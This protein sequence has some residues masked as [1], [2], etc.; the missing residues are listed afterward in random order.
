MGINHNIQSDVSELVPHVVRDQIFMIFKTMFEE[1]IA[2]SDF[3]QEGLN[4]DDLIVTVTLTEAD[5]TL[6]HLRF[7]FPRMLLMP[8]MRKI[9]GPILGSHESSFEDAV[10]EIANV[11]ANGVKRELNE[12]GYHFI[13]SQPKIEH[14]IGEQKNTKYTHKQECA[15]QV[16][17]ENINVL[18]GVE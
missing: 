12:N 18:I 5:N 3:R 13:M 7:T 17:D 15:F 11:T 16:R 2:E 9:Y 8:I 10:S 4:D 6:L 1:D 14:F